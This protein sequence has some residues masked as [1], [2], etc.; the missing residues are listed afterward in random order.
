MSRESDRP[1][2]APD[3]QALPALDQSFTANLARLNV[4]PPLA[5]AVSGGG[6]SVALMQL[7]AD[8]ASAQ[9]HSPN[10]IFVLTVDHGLRAGARAEATQVA[11]WARDLGFGHQ[12]LRWDAALAASG[13]LQERARAA[14]R[15]LMGRWCRDRDIS[16]LLLAHT[17]DDQLETVGMRLL[18]G[19]G[20]AG[21]GGMDEQIAGPFGVRLVRPLL[22]CSRAVLRQ[23]LEGRGIPW[24]EDPSNEDA[25]FE[26]V[27]MRRVLSGSSGMK[28]Q[29]ETL[30]GAGAEGRQALEGA[31]DDMLAHAVTMHPAGWAAL[32]L[33]ALRHAPEA[34]ARHSLSRLVL[35]LGG[36]AYPPR[37]ESLGRVHAALVAERPEGATLAGC[38]M[39]IKSPKSALLGREVRNIL[40]LDL[41]P[42]QWALWDHRIELKAPLR[43]VVYPL[44]DLGLDAL[45]KEDRGWV[46]AAVPAAFRGSLPVLDLEGRGIALPLLADGAAG[47]IEARFVAPRPFEREQVGAGAQDVGKTGPLAFARRN[48]IFHT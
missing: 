7:V 42:R 38:H 31:A 36:S 32:D 47:G 25:S 4:R 27:R 17:G 29:L 22:G 16:D 46:K 8:W 24:I 23:W 30:A 11:A 18:R 13:G 33:D 35:A 43:G 37:R 2:T 44:A 48:P 19:S 1:T 34:V 20:T 41:T 10:K 5:L 9:G 28:A 40:P 39:V 14:R 45:G 15:Q 21:L 26:R 3:A 12:V 6:D